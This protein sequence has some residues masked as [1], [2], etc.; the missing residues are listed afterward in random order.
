[1]VKKFGRA[2]IFALVF[3]ASIQ[4]IMVEMENRMQEPEAVPAGSL[5]SEGQLSDFG[6]PSLEW[7]LVSRETEDDYI[8]ETYREYEVYRDMEGEI[9]KKN[10]TDHYDYIR[11]KQ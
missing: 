4:L 2:G 3:L 8:V 10:S 6:I 7:Y 5:K 9:I 11:Y 1:M